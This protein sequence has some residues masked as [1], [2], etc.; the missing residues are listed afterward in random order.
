MVST[1]HTIQMEN[2]GANKLVYM[3]KNR[4]SNLALGCLEQT[5]TMANDQHRSLDRKKPLWD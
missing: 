1:T 3:E 2:L 4:Q 5:E